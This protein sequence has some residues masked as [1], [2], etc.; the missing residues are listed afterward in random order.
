[1]SGSAGITLAPKKMQKMA[2]NNA[3]IN[4]ASQGIR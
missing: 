4:D 3:F 2:V 1:L